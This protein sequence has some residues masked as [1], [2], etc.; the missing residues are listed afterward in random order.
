MPQPSQNP[1]TPANPPSAAPETQPAF[2]I[3]SIL[4]ETR[5]FDP[6]AASA[7]GA[8]YWHVPSMEAYRAMYAR[9]VADPEAFFAEAAEQLHWFRPWRRVLDW[10]P[11]DAKWF[12]G[13]TTNICYNCVDR[14]VENDRGNETALVW[15]AE[16]IG[17]AGTPEVRTLTYRELLREV[18]KFANVLKKLGVRKGDV[19]TIYM[20]MVPELAIACLACARIGAVHSVIFGGFSSQAIA[21]RVADAQSRVIVTC[22]GA[23]RR[24]KVV[25]LKENVD[26]AV[27]ELNASGGS[28][29]GSLLREPLVRHVVYFKRTMN[30]IVWH[31]DRDY[32]WRDL[33]VMAD[34]WCPCEELDSE[35]AAFILYT[36]GSTGKPK[37]ILHTV[38]GY[39]LH[40]AMTAKYTF[41]LIPGLHEPV[42]TLKDDR[43]RTLPPGQLYWCTAD[44]GWVTGHSYILYGVMANR[45]PTLIYE[46][47]PNFPKDDRFWDIVQRH[48]VTQFYTAPTAIRAF[49]K[50]GA[51]H[52]ARHDLT[53][54]QVLGS[55]GEPINPEAWMWYRE[56]IGRGLCPIVDTWWQTETGG[57]MLT[58]L[59]GA[60]PT[61]PGSCGLPFFGVDAAICDEQ[62]REIAKGGG[63]LAVRKPWPGM[64]RGVFGDRER[65]IKTYWSKFE[66]DQAQTTL[67]GAALGGAALRAASPAHQPHST[68]HAEGGGSESRPTQGQPL[69]SQSGVSP[70]YF[71]GDGAHRDEDGYF[72]IL[73]RVD[74]VINV[75]GHRLGTMEVESALVSHEAV[76]EAAVVG[77]PHEVKGTGIAAFCTLEPGHAPKSDADAERLRKA[78]AEHVSKEIGAIARPDQIRF[79]DALPKTRSG[80][81]MRRLLR[82][83]AAGESHTRQDTSTLEDYSVL[84]RL[85]EAKES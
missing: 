59:P 50:W 13:G 28:G 1:H 55:V 68:G 34:D 8:P 74:D 45:V 42:R 57:H 35:D 3:D 24:G 41:N 43:G 69:Q 49:M 77:M 72:W 6:P 80:K 39:L 73:G 48:R 56:H 31:A 53:S 37:G 84:A 19:V 44:I 79:T 33:M 71:P 4:K 58:P 29:A 27:N 51:E 20:G 38:G 52:P 67:G 9:S 65:F 76:V 32:S 16:P 18:C 11:P 10:N 5:R 60:T 63:L 61:K 66:V 26:A 85:G 40:A 75:S 22:D 64:L 81:I 47:A 25:P 21:D 78:L 46:G 54:L 82:S 36:S 83:I 12:V 62:G 7:V 15:E 17:P 2:G 23:W 30:Q 70:Y 14:H